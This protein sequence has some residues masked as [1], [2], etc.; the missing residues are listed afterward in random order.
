MMEYTLWEVIENGPTLPK[1]QF[2]EGVTTFMPITSVEDKAQ[3]RLEVK[4][5]STLMMGIPNEHQLKFNSIKDATQLLEDI[6]K[7]FVSQPNSPELVNEDLK[8]IHLDDLEDIDLRWQMAMLTMRAR[9]TTTKGDTLLGSTELQEV[10]IPSTRRIVHVKTPASTTLVS[11]DG[12]GGY[13]WSEQAKEGPNYALMAC[14]S[15]NSDLKVS[16][17]STCTKSC[18][19]TVKILKSQNEQLLKDLK[20][21]ELIALGCKSGIESVEERLRFFKTNE[22]V[23]I[24]DIKLLKVKIKMKD[25][26]IK[27]LRRKLEVAQKEKNGIQLT[28]E[29]IRNASKSINKLIDCQIVN[30]CK[31]GLGYESY[32]ALLPLY[33]GNFMPKKP[34]LSYIG[35]DEFADKP[36]VENCDAKTS[37]TKPKD[38][39]KN[40]DALL[41][42]E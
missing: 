8:Q 23:Y 1:T 33:I 6:E 18:L 28:I 9:R 7:R 31:K 22:S 5:R 17:D 12:F 32:N 30:N 10:K 29:K 15:I 40:N 20:K 3:R 2:V 4:A 21:S 13:D 35:L 42:E 39:R 34:D 24:E 16:T 38:V 36:V 19:E 25:I 26:A 11:C 37:E 41:I 27:E 14:T